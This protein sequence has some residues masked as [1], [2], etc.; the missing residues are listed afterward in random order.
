MKNRPSSLV[1]NAG[2]RFLPNPPKPPTPPKP[3]PPKRALGALLFAAAMLATSPCRA[4]DIA[5]IYAEALSNDP[6]LA[7]ARASAANVKEGV[8]Q[9]RARFLPSVNASASRS[10]GR[11][12]TED[13]ERD[14]GGQVVQI[15]G[16]TTDTERNSWGASVSQEV[17]NLPSWFLYRSAKATA[18]GA[19]WDLLAASQDLIIRVAQAYLGVLRTQAALESATAAEEAVQRQLEQVQ[20]RFD[21]GLVA[22]TGVLESKAEYD[23]AVVLRIQSQ[24]N[25]DNSFEALRTLTGKPYAE[26]SRLT[27]SLPIVDPAPSAEAEWVAAAMTNSPRIG[28]ARQRLKAAESDLKAAYAA[29]VPSISANISY[30]AGDG[31][32]AFNGQVFQ[33]PGSSSTS[34]SL[35]LSVPI[36]RG[37]QE[38]SGMRRARLGV[39]QARH[40]LLQQELSV[41]ENVR[42]LFRNVQVHVVRVQARGEAIKSSQAALE[43]TQTGYEVGTRN[44]VDVLLAQRRLFGSQFDYADAR[45]SYVLDLLRLK[46]AAGSLSEQDVGDLNQHTDATD[47]VRPTTA[48]AG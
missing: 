36:F 7:G 47:P 1:R 24:G 29:P 18:E 43:A 41:A 48:G 14:I 2:K 21:V 35:S 6:V 13:S 22:I 19:D 4:A 46:Q 3:N 5:E 8:A 17:L 23:N 16:R 12:E 34:Y 30:G 11:S 15:P 40:A 42:N 20:Q 25:H 33:D 27:E 44:I 45:Y 39:E 38:Y 9:A 32:S 37:L 10:Q 31:S 28:A 26:L